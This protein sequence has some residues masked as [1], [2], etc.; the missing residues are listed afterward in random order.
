MLHVGFAMTVRFWRG[1]QGFSRL[2]AAAWIIEAV[3]AAI[4]LPEIHTIGD[5]SQFWFGLA[6]LLHVPA[7]G[8]LLSSA[9]ALVGRKLPRRLMV[10]FYGLSLPAILLGRLLGP[11]LAGALLPESDPTFWAVLFNLL[12]MFVPATVIRIV[13]V[14]WMYQAW[15]RDRDLG[16][17]VSA[18][19]GIQWAIGAIVVPFQFYFS[20]YPM[21]WNYMWCLRMFGFS[22]G[23]L[24][25]IISRAERVLRDN[26]ELR[27]AL[28]KIAA[29][30]KLIGEERLKALG[31]MAAGVAHD[32]N[33]SLTPVVAYS[34]LLDHSQNDPKRVGELARLIQVAADDTAATVRRLEHFYRKTHNRELLRIVDLADAVQEA[35]VL[36]RPRWQDQARAS[37]KDISVSA[38]LTAHPKV[39]GDVSQL[40]SVLVNLIFN[41]CDA[42]TDSGVIEVR[43]DASGDDATVTVFD[44]GVGMSA[45][46]IE[47]CLEPFYSTKPTGSGLGL[48]ECHGIIRQHAGQIAVESCPGESTTVRIV[49][50][51][52]V[53]CDESDVTPVQS[54]QESIGDALVVDDDHDV[55]TATAMIL[56]DVAANVVCV[57]DGAEAVE[58]ISRRHF[59]VVVTDQGLPGMNG[60]EVMQATRSK[61]PET[62]VIIISGWSLPDTATPGPDAFVPKPFQPDDLRIAVREACR[63]RV[64]AAAS[65]AE[66][67]ST[68]NVKT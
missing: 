9:A 14:S 42:I 27:A 12:I 65:P 38:R 60:V 49:L 64:R 52:V 15:T 30:P 56:Q 23:I 8:L 19:F 3:R 25:L 63:Q 28:E 26:K 21:W 41:A 36:T 16:G 18:F 61:S 48:S 37:G 1:N 44:T 39:K 17:L 67:D 58:L 20:W 54:L 62:S 32:I 46:Q 29:T 13:V 7:T 53:E 4:L 2:F 45:E 51:I 66:T 6:E 5:V 68:P 35:I 59:D 40:R 57:H 22:M 47:R 10:L 11:T 24:M 33:N 43:V 55:A 31:Q 34:H 50:P